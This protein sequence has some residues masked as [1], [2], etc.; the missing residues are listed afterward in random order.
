MFINL[1]L[2][3][4]DLFAS[5]LN[6]IKTDDWIIDDLFKDRPDAERH[7]IKKYLM[8]RRIVTDIQEQEESPIYVIPSFVLNGLPFPQIAIHLGGENSQ[9]HFVGM[10]TGGDPI[11]VMKNNEVVA[12]D[13]ER[14]YYAAVNYRADI[15][16]NSKDEVIW[17]SRICQRAIAGKILE[18]DEMGVIEPHIGTADTELEQKFY[19]AIVFSRAVVFSGKSLHTWMERAPVQEPY[20]I[21]DNTVVTGGIA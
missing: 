2:Y 8:S 13:Q 9:D 19:P 14:G 4:R 18:L 7:A 12:W 17:L 1:D 16:A 15:I 10:E 6:Q 20:E 21:G 11:P 3:F 5:F